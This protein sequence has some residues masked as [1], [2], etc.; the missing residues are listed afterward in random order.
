MRKYVERS[1]KAS[2]PTFEIIPLLDEMATVHRGSKRTA[3]ESFGGQ[4][5]CSVNSFGEDVHVIISSLWARIYG[6]SCSEYLEKQGSLPLETK[7]S[8]KDVEQALG[9]MGDSVLKLFVLGKEGMAHWWE[10]KAGKN[11]TIVP[12]QK[13]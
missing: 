9:L 7:R 2:A 6:A 10:L 3:H 12:L 1:L 11:P 13:E 5:H 4:D 8:V